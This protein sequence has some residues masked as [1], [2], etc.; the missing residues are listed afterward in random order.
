MGWWGALVVF[1]L[2]W[3]GLALLDDWAW[4]RDRYIPYI[5]DLVRAASIPVRVVVIALITLLFTDHFITK[6][7]F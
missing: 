3:E 6:L 5:T 2:G 1:I 4:K 7:V